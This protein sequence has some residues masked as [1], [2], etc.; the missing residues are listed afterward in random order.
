MPRFNAASCRRLNVSDLIRQPDNTSGAAAA[1]VLSTLRVVRIYRAGQDSVH[2]KL[3][4]S[5]FRFSSGRNGCKCGKVK[6]NP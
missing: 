5:I 1:L 4:F 3:T 2:W 6:V